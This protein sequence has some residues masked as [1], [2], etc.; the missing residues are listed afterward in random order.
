MRNLA[1]DDPMSTF[2]K[3]KVVSLFSGAGGLDLGFFQTG[4]YDTLLANELLTAPVKTYIHNFKAKEI[5][6]KPEREDL[7]AVFL[8]DIKDLEFT[9]LEKEQIDVI[10][11][12]PPCQ[13][14]SIV[15]GPSTERQGLEVKRGNLYTHFIRSLV[16]LQPNYFVFEN[17]LGIK[18]ANKGL[19][20][21][22][23]IEDFKY[24]SSKWEEAKNDAGLK[25]NIK[26]EIKSYNILFSD[27]ITMSYLGVPQKRR[28]VIILGT[29]KTV[30]VQIIY[31]IN[32]FL[33][34]ENSIFRKF[35][36]TTMEVF[37]GKPLPEL[38]EK[39][40]KIMREYEG[41]TDEVNTEKAIEWKEE[42]WSNLS[43]NIITDYLKTN[44][45][46]P[47]SENLEDVFKSHKNLLI[48]L[49]YYEKNV[50]NV[51]SEDGTNKIPYESEDIRSRMKFIPPDENS[52][53]VNGT[54]WH[55]SGRGMS[56]IYRRIH[57]LKPAYT[58]VAYG[59]GGTWTYHY[60]RER[61]AITNRE[62]ARLQTFPD[63]FQFKGNKQEIR[64]QIGE[65]VPPLIGKRIA[66]LLAETMI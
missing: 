41:I 20:W 24:L 3:Y 2:K 28:R 21:N 46:M 31:K 45:I 9:G 15:R 47:F 49:G 65:A 16:A 36:L 17:V 27:D 32:K 40:E 13:D 29:K 62:R 22:T 58:V 19:A 56:L 10:I 61:S 52:E 1:T 64:A 25:N 35:P 55:V 59:G 53:F 5:S 7:P 8:G 23:I 30:D 4:K 38:Q 63:E 54:K 33:K 26:N 48:E 50:K 11:G 39:Y 37:E 42:T 60:E 14:F 6:K 34:G 57:P 12:G 18:S 43:F 44:N 66:E 51:D